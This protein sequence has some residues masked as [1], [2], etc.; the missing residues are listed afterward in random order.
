MRADR[1]RMAQRA[2]V[3]QLLRDDHHER[4][5]RPEL[6]AELRGIEQQIVVSAV[7]ML[8]IEGV[9]SFD[10]TSICATRCARHLDELGLVGI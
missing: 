1:I 6:E 10:D 4:W 8:G 3:M 5:T 2:I 9:A 7:A